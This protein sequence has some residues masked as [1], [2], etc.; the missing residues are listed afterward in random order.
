MIPSAMQDP[1]KKRSLEDMRNDIP[2][3]DSM[4]VRETM[5]R[6]SLILNSI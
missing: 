1:M 4:M 5:L 3:P 6:V 2:A